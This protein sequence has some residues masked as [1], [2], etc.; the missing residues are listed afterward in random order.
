M[1]LDWRRAGTG[2]A[3]REIYLALKHLAG[4]ARARI[5]AARKGIPKPAAADYFKRVPG[6]L[7]KP[8]ES[9]TT[10]AKYGR[11]RKVTHNGNNITCAQHVGLGGK[12]ALRIHFADLDDGRLLIGHA[13]KH[14]RTAT[15]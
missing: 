10:M 7:Y 5:E 3:V 1:H 15:T 2:D 14:L 8:R 12:L 6:L 11:L 13:G 9:K 4:F